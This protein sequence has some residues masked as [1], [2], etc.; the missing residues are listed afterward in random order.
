MEGQLRALARAYGVDLGNQWRA[1]QV[2]KLVKGDDTIE[3]VRQRI[4]ELAMRE[5]KSF[6]DAIAGG[7]TVADVADPYI[8]KMASLLEM[9]PADISVSNRLIQ[10]ALKQR[11]PD[12][13]PAAMDLA[14]FEDF[15][16]KDK[17]WQYTD[18]AREEMSSIVASL[19]QAF[20][21]LA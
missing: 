16:R 3:G 7:Q 8:Q 2:K 10:K 12:G 1:N 14:D 13:K 4:Q 21:L 9:N 15:I 11:T 17:R 18:N 5:Y 19:G 20:G 6:A